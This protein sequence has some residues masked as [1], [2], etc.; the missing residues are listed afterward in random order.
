MRKHTRPWFCLSKYIKIF[1]ILQISLKKRQF[2]IFLR[3]WEVCGCMLH[4][5]TSAPSIICHTMQYNIS[6]RWA[7]HFHEQ[8]ELCLSLPGVFFCKMKRKHCVFAEIEPVKKK[9]K[10]ACVSRFSNK[11][12]HTHFIFNTRKSGLWLMR[13]MYVFTQMTES[14]VAGTLLIQKNY[15]CPTLCEHRKWSTVMQT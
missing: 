8:I 13:R 7:T 1:L 10:S 6:W 11:N 15:T 14:G 5:K 2:Y 4:V 12:T 3:K 9:E